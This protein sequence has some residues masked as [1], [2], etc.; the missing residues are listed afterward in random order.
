MATMSSPADLVR[1][2]I[3]RSARLRTVAKSRPAQHLIA[4]TRASRIAKPSGAFGARQFATRGRCARYEIGGTPVYVR[5]GTRDVA[6]MVEIFGSRPIY[7]PPDEVARLLEQPLRILDLGGNVGLFD[8]VALDRFDVTDLRSYE[9]DPANLKL[10]RATAGATPQW[11]VIEAAAGTERG[12]LPFL[13]DRFC[14]TR[15]ARDGEAGVLVP[16]RDV[17]AESACDLLKMDIEGGEWPILADPRLD[18]FARVIVVEWHTL[19]PPELSTAPLVASRLLTE[20]GYPHQLEL[21]REHDGNGITWAW[22]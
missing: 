5:H 15:S 4:T 14:E 11:H 17:R 10:L 22:R 9:P 19:G 20:R 1:R 18:G 8:A 2:A 7:E 13:I 12:T 16:V 21:P 3:D 6:I